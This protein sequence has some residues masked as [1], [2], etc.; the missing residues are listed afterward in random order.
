MEFVIDNLREVLLSIVNREQNNT[1]SE[2]SELGTPGKTEKTRQRTEP[3]KP[4]D[5]YIEE[6]LCFSHP[7]S[8]RKKVPCDNR[9]SHCTYFLF[10][11]PKIPLTSN[12]TKHPSVGYHTPGG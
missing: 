3:N 10:V 5:I 2:V 11:S 6:R 12:V 1:V 8:H 4:H 9:L 7:P